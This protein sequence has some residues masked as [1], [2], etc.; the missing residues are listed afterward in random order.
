MRGPPSAK[1]GCCLL[2]DPEHFAL[3]LEPLEQLEAH[4][5]RGDA[6]SGKRIPRVV[7][8]RQ[9]SQPPT[10]AS[11]ATVSPVSTSTTASPG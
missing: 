5:L 11:R 7:R 9:S 1:L 3:P 10:L 2:Q 6:G 8:I 4:R